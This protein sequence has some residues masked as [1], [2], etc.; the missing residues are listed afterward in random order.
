[1]K[2]IRKIEERAYCDSSLIW[3]D[4]N[5]SDNGMWVFT[6]AFWLSF[7]LLKIKI[8]KGFKVKVSFTG[9]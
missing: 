2:F 8:F 7:G 5:K 4:F 3:L 1:M 6:L 9:T